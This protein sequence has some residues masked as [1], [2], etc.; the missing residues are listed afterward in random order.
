M[1]LSSL[2]NGIVPLF[3][4][5]TFVAK[6][7]ERYID[8]M[9]AILQI[10]DVFLLL[11]T[12]RGHPWNPWKHE[13]PV[14]SEHST[15]PAAGA[16]TGAETRD[17]STPGLQ[18]DTDNQESPD[19][20]AARPPAIQLMV[21]K[22]LAAVS[23]I[24]ARQT[25]VPLSDTARG[26]CEGTTGTGPGQTVQPEAENMQDAIDQGAPQSFVE[27]ADTARLLYTFY[28][29][30]AADY[31]CAKSGLQFVRDAAYRTP[32]P[33]Q[34]SNA[35]P[36]K[37]TMLYAAMAD[38]NCRSD[39]CHSM[40]MVVCNLGRAVATLL[41][42]LWPSLRLVGV[43]ARW[44]EDDK[45]NWDAA[46]GEL[47]QIEA[48]ALNATQVTPAPGPTAGNADLTPLAAKPKQRE[49][50]GARSPRLWQIAAETRLLPKV[51]GDMYRHREVMS[52]GAELV[53]EAY[54]AGAFRGDSPLAELGLR[55]RH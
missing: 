35:F 15:Q 39:Q 11:D 41:P 31:H 42:A 4:S 34:S 37:G 47:R 5:A 16:P 32:G 36:A 55:I 10:P 13:L 18:A 33:E 17:D 22:M 24:H 49:R 30:D 19:Q 3:L 27:I 20:Q 52:R 43:G 1:F 21:P 26:H 44:H 23:E 46:I 9:E 40:A 25:E 8:G 12:P 38:Y 6:N 7:P 14:A 50:K 54:K 51:L 53:L 28:P 29:K 48:A 2:K 45:F